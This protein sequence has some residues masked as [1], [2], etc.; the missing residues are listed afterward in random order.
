MLC[1]D[2][3]SLAV[4]MAS[5]QCWKRESTSINGSA[6][7]FLPSCR[8]L[9]AVVITNPWVGKHQKVAPNLFKS[10]PR[11]FRKKP[12]DK[13]GKRTVILRRPDDWT[14]TSDS[15]PRGERVKAENFYHW[16]SIKYTMPS[17]IRH[18]VERVVWS[19]TKPLAWFALV[20]EIQLLRS[21][22]EDISR[23]VICCTRPFS[24]E[25]TYT[26]SREGVTW[27]SLSTCS[28]SRSS[29]NDAMLE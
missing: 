13:C 7:T 9:K 6:T 19:R 11:N 3:V 20:R 2:S 24:H 1:W 16:I 15:A 8:S 26:L 22:Y 29:E 17:R 10:N 18:I 27:Q 28:F 25:N 4:Q 14:V 12:Y 21:T 23:Q 5:C